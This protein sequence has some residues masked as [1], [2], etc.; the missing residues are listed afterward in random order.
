[1]SPQT[2]SPRSGALLWVMCIGVAAVMAAGCGRA[3]TIAGTP[4]MTGSATLP[5]PEVTTQ[6]LSAGTAPRA[7]LDGT[8]AAGVRQKVTLSVQ[9]DMRQLVAGQPEERFVT[10]DVTIPLT[11]T[12]NTGRIVLLLG[13]ATSSDAILSAELALAAGVHAALVTDSHG[14]VTAFGL[15]AAERTGPEARE[16]LERCLAQAIEQLIVFPATPIGDGAQWLIRRQVPG[17]VPL[18]QTTR[19]T[20]LSHTGGVLRVQVS[21]E[22]RVADT[23]VVTADRS[24]SSAASGSADLDNPIRGNG[25]FVI[26]QRL[27]LPVSGDI[28]IEGDRFYR[29]PDDTVQLSQITAIRVRWGS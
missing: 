24:A 20:L 12:A 17:R 11:A 29:A 28:A 6:L 5:V 7:R 9:K 23:M 1:M 8:A 19:A 25:V 26:D 15:G 18:E 27:P 22:Q 4:Q 2:A 3:G 16:A 10:P 21:I 14:S 13:I